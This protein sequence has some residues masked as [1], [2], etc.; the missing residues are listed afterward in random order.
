MKNIKKK[1]KQSEDLLEKPEFME[2]KLKAEDLEKI[3]EF[4]TPF[5]SS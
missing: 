2:H 3:T 5:L 1:M 4:Q